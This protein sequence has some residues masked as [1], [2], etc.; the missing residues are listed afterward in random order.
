MNSDKKSDDA[1]SK[2]KLVSIGVPI[3]KRLEYLPS[4]LKMVGGQDYPFI[5]LIVSDNGQNGTKVSDMLRAQYRR[6]YRFRQ[7]D[8]T[9]SI[10]THYNQIISAASGD[11]F[12][13]L[14][15]DDEI[16]SNFVSELV[17]QLERHPEASMA[18]ARQEII[19]GEGRVIRK[20]KDQLPDILSGP[21][22]IRSTWGRYEYDF[23]NLET[24]LSKRKI[25]LGA[26][27]YPD[28]V[29]G[30]HSDDAAAIR[31]ALNHYVVFSSRCVFRHRVYEGGGGWQ[32]SIGELSTA[33]RQFMQFLDDDPTIRAFEAEN[34]AE[35]QDLR[36]CLVNMSLGTYFW[37]WR[38]IYRDRLST[39]EWVKAAFTMPF[40]PHYYRRVMS[41]FRKAAITKVK[42]L[43]TGHRNER[44]SF[45]QRGYQD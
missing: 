36:R 39:T 6:P 10:I 45:F 34:P 1:A 19:N 4:V 44:G 27:G 26:G 37:R 15:D 43:L 2:G 41:V 11:Y 25:L 31:T 24:F 32:A 7:N 3:Y 13:N 9:V 20:S 21:E 28:F 14:D 30:N 8:S 23:H 17:G 18:Y 33:C 16:S 35:W 38:D 22:F 40:V 5:E 42:E 12:V 29:R